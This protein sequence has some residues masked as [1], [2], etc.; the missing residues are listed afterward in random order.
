MGH[1]GQNASLLAPANVIL[2]TVYACVLGSEY[3]GQF[4]SLWHGKALL[5][6]GMGLTI[7]IASG[8]CV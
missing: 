1:Q 5:F 2:G 4:L 6:C 7:D 3:E 8:S